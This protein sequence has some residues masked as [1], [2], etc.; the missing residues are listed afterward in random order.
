M[1][2]KLRALVVRIESSQLS[3]QEKDEI[4]ASLAEGLHTTV[5]PTII[6]Y[7]PKDKLDAMA[8]D[9]PRVTVEAYGEL[10][11]ASIQDGQALKEIATM[12]DEI[13]TAVDATLTAHGVSQVS[14]KNSV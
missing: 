3:Q 12:M 5:W 11:E 13:L 9:A 4:Y 7:L 1:E 14:E 10:I 8:A 6:K 2:D